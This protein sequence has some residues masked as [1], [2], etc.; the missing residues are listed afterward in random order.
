MS[1]NPLAPLW[2][3]VPD[4]VNDVASA[5]WSE[6]SRRTDEGELSI[7][8]VTASSLAEQFGTEVS[9]FQAAFSPHLAE[10]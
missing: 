2:L 3:A 1:A 9:R 7:G 6:N 5:V 10:S 4:D 8:G